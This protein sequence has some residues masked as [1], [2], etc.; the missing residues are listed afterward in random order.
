M[1][2]AL[3][4]VKSLKAWYGDFQ[5]LYGID[6]EVRERQVVAIIGANGAGK[7]TLLKTIVGLLPAPAQSIQ[8][9]GRPIGGMAANDIVKLGIALV[10]E[11]RR[12]F[13]SLSV[14]ENLL[15]GGRV[16]RPGP[17]TLARIYEMFPVLAERRRTRPQSCRAGSS[18]WWQ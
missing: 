15:L 14:E 18:K 7:S 6:L 2:E 10:P 5:A 9:N 13:A 1:S 11:G 3:L 17:W 4:S 12:L 16:R 8:M